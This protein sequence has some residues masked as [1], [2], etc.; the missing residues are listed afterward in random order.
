[1][2]RLKMAASSRSTSSMPPSAETIAADH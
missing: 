2:S 1:V